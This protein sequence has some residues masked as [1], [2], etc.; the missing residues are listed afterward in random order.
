VTESQP[1]RRIPRLLLCATGGYECAMLPAFVLSLLRHCADDVQVVLTRAAEKIA[2]R[3]AIEVAS[4]HAVF[5]D[6]TDARDGVFVPHIELSRRA[7]AI[8]VYP[9]TVNILGKVA[10]GITDELVSA[11]IVAATVPVFFVPVTN[12]AMWRHPATQ[13]NVQ[14]LSQD[15]YVVLP[16]VASVEV[17]TREGLNES[18]APFPFPTLLL[19]LQAAIAPSK[20]ER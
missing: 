11:L 8:V 17:A 18:A 1:P 5:V 6:M 7:D 14:Q 19:R 16:N 3:Y 9:A 20:I 4:R 15:G 10:N 2:S 13:R 12:D